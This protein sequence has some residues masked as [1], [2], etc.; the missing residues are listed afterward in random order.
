MV[1]YTIKEIE[2][3]SGVKAHTLRVWEKRYGIVQP[4]RTDTNIR[5][6]TDDHLKKILNISFLNRNNLKISKIAQLSDEELKRKVSELSDVDIAFEDQLDALVLSI[7]ELDRFNFNK[8]LDQH[9]ELLGFEQTMKEMIYP[10]MD[11]LSIMWMAGSLK[12]VQES[13]VT[14][15]VKA[16]IIIANEKLA[17]S[18]EEPKAIVMIYLPENEN[19]ELSL[20]YLDF[21]LKN[22]NYKVI[23]LGTNISLD[24]A[25]DGLKLSDAPYVFTI[26]NDSFSGGGLKEYIDELTSR[27]PDTTLLISGMQPIQQKIKNSSNC[28]VLRSLDDTVKYLEEIKG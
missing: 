19:H 13:F 10:L 11:K 16:K 20:L 26:V 27:A 5:F 7:L 22:R 12:S 15:C 6:Y 1:V 17:F 23:N 21:L 8:I 9:I 25:I 4:N 28:K 14:T 18:K 24:E 2:K 3:L